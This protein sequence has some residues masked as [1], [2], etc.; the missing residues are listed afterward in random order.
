VL[1]AAIV[2]CIIC[3]GAGGTAFWLQPRHPPPEPA[4]AAS[5]MPS[6]ADLQAKAHLAHLPVQE[7][8]DPF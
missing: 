7:F 1:K 3:A 8:K 2:A 6:L 5:G 4:A